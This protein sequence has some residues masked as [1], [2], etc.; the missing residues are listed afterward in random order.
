MIYSEFHF[1][2]DLHL[3]WS[4]MIVTYPLLSGIMAGAFAVTALHIS[5]GLESLRPVS[6]FSLLVSLAFLVC[7]TLPLLNH[8]GRPE[9]ALN[10]VIVPN[11]RSAIGG[12]GYIYMVFF[13]ILGMIVWFSHREELIRRAQGA[14]GL[15]RMALNALLLWNH[16]VDDETRAVDKTVIFYLVS[17]GIPSMAVLSGYV[18]FLFGSLKSNPWWSTPVMPF[19]FFTSGLMSGMALVTLMYLY[20]G[21]LG[22][23]EKSYECLRTLA[24]LLWFSTSL[25]VI[26]EGVEL[27]YFYYESSDA[28]FVISTLLLTKLKVSFFF[29]QIGLGLGVAFLLLSAMFALRLDEATFARL[30]AIASVFLLFEVWMMRWNIV[31]GGQLFSKSYVGFREFHP[32]WFEKEGIFPAIAFTILPFF[33]LWAVTRLLSIGPAEESMPDNPASR[34]EA[35]GNT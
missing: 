10:V 27:L 29:L 6:R 26:L 8:L 19:V 15:K 32:V 2:N 21:W 14:R 34:A 3:I 35:G 11:H 31:V 28:W 17:I 22:Y 25:Y 23:L 33:V 4:L 9:R 24:A 5:F 18:G 12:F 30:A 13:A 1:P 7:I 16:T 20:L